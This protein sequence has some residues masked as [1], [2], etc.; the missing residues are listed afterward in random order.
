MNHAM[1]GM[2]QL[3]GKAISPGQAEGRILVYREES[4]TRG[5]PISIEPETIDAELELLKQAIALITG[6]LQVLAKRLGQE[7]DAGTAA[8]FEAHQ[9]MLN[10]PLLR[11]ELQD[12]VQNHLMS[13]ASAVSAVFLR[14]EQRFLQMDSQL[15]QQKAADMRDI[16]Q[17]LSNALSGIE[18]HPFT[19]MPEGCVLVASRILPSDAIHL[20][21]RKIA[22]VLLE[23]GQAGSHAALFIRSMGLPCISDIAGL[24]SQATPDALALVDADQGVVVISPTPSDR[25]AY[26]QKVASHDRIFARALARTD[27]P[28]V[29]RDGITI[30]VN[31]NVGCRADTELAVAN[32]ADGIGLYRTEQMYLASVEP[33]DTNTLLQEMRY[34]LGPAQRLPVC[35]R[36][37]DVGADKQLS[38][39]PLLGENNPALGRRGIRMQLALPKMLETQLRAILLLSTEFDVRILVPMVTL[40]GDLQEVRRC[41]TRLAPECGVSTLPPLGAMIE[42]PAAALTLPDL[43]PYVDFASFGTNDLAQYVFAADRESTAEE[44]YYQDSHPAI[45]RLLQIAHADAPRMPLSICGELGGRVAHIPALLRCGCRS[46]S[47][48]PPL[49][50]AIKAGIRAARIASDHQAADHT[51]LVLTG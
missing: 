12:Q 4:E 44:R 39:L 35:V 30:A 1:H 10:D 51:S 17:R 37:F 41:M 34:T 43:E 19:Q 31:A 20:A 49:I 5:M 29:T 36:L 21:G 45:F 47:V 50:P 38:F 7:M 33:P 24:L 26:Q 18:S 2:T 11:D 3:H 42:T 23:Q 40:P 8:V 48:V 15:F 13:A 32:G 28:A 22:A 6:D 14:W 16:A 25:E 9:M 46:L 27:Q